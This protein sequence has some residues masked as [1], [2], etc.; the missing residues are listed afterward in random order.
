[1]SHDGQVASATGSP[2]WAWRLICA[3]DQDGVR[4]IARR[5]IQKVV[6]PSDA[7]E[8]NRQSVGFWL[9]VRDAQEHPRYVRFMRNPMPE[10]V[11]VPPE[12]GGAGF[13]HLPAPRRGTFALLVPDVAEGDHVS[14]MRRAPR[15]AGIG[16]AAAG[17]A[18]VARLPLGGA[19]LPE[20]AEEGRP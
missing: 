2:Q 19:N 12:P 9:E 4:V 10:A 1:M 16:V 7:L 17:P 14:L 5:R 8:R 20:A 3:Y 13:T 6:P 18:E 11:E 15:S